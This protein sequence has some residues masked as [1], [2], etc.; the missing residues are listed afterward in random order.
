MLFTSHLFQICEISVSYSTKVSNANRPKIA[1]SKDCFDVVLPLWD[2]IEYRESFLVLLMNRA[3]RLLGIVE[4]SKGG[5]SGT[6]ADPKLIFQ[7][8]LKANASSLIMCHNHPSG[9][10]QPSEADIRLTRKLKE[11]GLLLDLPVLD[12]LIVTTD[13]YYSFA[14]E[15]LI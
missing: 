1:G 5:V 11:G 8:A 13:G 9:N 3:N 4:V 10:T 7:H 2:D 6:V 14:D 12:H 15:G